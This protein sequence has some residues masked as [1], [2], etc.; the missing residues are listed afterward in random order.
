MEKHELIDISV[1]KYDPDLQVRVRIKKE[2]I[3]QYAECMETEE[4]LKHFPEIEVYFDGESYWLADGHHRVEAAKKRK[5]T[6]ISAVVRRGS[7]DDAIWA[8]ILANAKQGVALTKADRKR[9]VEIVVKRWP[10]KSVRLIAETVKVSHMTVKRIRD[11]FSGVTNV[12]PERTVGKDGK[13]YPTKQKTRKQPKKS[14]ISKPVQQECPS[15]EENLIEEP[16]ERRTE[17][18]SLRKGEKEQQTYS[19][20]VRFEPDPD[21]DHFDWITREEREELRVMQ[22]ECP[23][24]KLVPL[25][26]NYTIQSIPEHDPD[27]LISC[28]FSLFQPLYRKKL[29]YAFARKMFAQGEDDTVREAIVTLKEEFQL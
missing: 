10:E 19:C 28:L 15:V 29:L 24:V 14:S 9:A 25:I 6:R 18:V 20:G 16:S 22:K 13:S 21:D 12:T 1:L 23:A 5:H 27:Y 11:A 4:D 2:M 7:L 8:A 26:R 17:I 3:D